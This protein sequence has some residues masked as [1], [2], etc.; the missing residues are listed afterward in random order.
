[1]ARVRALV[2]TRPSFA[3]VRRHCCWKLFNGANLH[4]DVI[5]VAD[6]PTTKRAPFYNAFTRT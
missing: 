1:V 4:T 2:E 3:F 6:A 5:L